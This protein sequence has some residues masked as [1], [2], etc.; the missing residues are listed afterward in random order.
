MHAALP[1]LLPYMRDQDQLVAEAAKFEERMIEETLKEIRADATLMEGFETE[2]Q[3]AHYFTSIIG[4]T[5][6]QQR[7]VTH[8]MLRA[9]ATGDIEKVLRP[10]PA[11]SRAAAATAATWPRQSRRCSCRPCRRHRA[12]SAQPRHGGRRSRRWSCSSSTAWTRTVLYVGTRRPVSG[13]REMVLCECGQAGCM[14]SMSH[15]S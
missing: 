12:P 10:P 7:A 1:P 8:Q 5:T 6:F 3:A 15:V 11:V 9:A 13:Q 4:F 2:L 14:V